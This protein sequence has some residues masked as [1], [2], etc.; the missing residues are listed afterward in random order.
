MTAH[1]VERQILIPRVNRFYSYRV[2]RMLRKIVALSANFYHGRLRKQQ[3]RVRSVRRM[4]SRA[5]PFLNG[6]V[7]GKGLFLPRDCILVTAAAEARHRVLEKG[8]LLGS[9]RAVTVHTTS[10]IEQRPM[11]PVLRQC[12]IDHVVVASAAELKAA[13]FCL[14]GGR[15]CGRIM[16]LVAHLVC[17]R[18]M[19]SIIQ[20]GGSCRSVRIVA[21][22]AAGIADR[23]IRMNL[24]KERLI[25]LMAILAETGDVLLQ[26]MFA[27]GRAVGI[28]A[29]QASRRNGPVLVFRLVYGV[30]QFLVAI[31]AQLVSRELKVEFIGRSM[32]IMTFDATT[33]GNRLVAALCLF[34]D[35]F[36]V[37]GIA[38]ILSI[39]RQK[40]AMRRRMWTVTPDAFPLPEWCMHVGALQ[41]FR[42]RHVAGQAYFS[43][44]PRFQFEFVLGVRAHCGSRR[45]AG[46][47]EQY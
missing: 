11:N 4:A 5:H 40:F 43:L 14:E 10:L 31:K 12:R 6:I 3:D 37:A 7:L 29:V 36:S 28:M 19:Y 35:D 16:T 38:N 33:F 22:R 20:Q 45:Q 42:E 26:K 1:A 2:R 18:R 46:D 25:S 9:V 24:Y 13:L 41:L 44:G 21:H 17:N 39:S 8:R 30:A 32:R 27:F 23:I 47:D 34:R 15:R